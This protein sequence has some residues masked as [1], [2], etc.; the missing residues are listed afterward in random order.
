MITGGVKCCGGF[1][2]EEWDGEEEMERMTVNCVDLC[3]DG[4][5]S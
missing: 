4:W 5:S 2:L 1:A 3:G